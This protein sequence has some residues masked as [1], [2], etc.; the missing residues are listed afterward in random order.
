MRLLLAFA[1]L[2]AASILPA[3]AQSFEEPAALIEYAYQQY[4]PGGSGSFE[5][6]E[7]ASADLQALY[8]A[9]DAQTLDGEV[10]AL[11]FDPIINGQ[12]YE[13]SDVSMSEIARDD[14]NAIVEVSF[15]NFEQ[16][17]S[18]RYALVL[19]EDGWKIDEI[20][21]VQPGFEWQLTDIL[22]SVQ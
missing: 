14:A 9:D 19:T 21:S 20:Q 22:A 3:S 5:V 13:I 6:R 16:V 17:Q 2:L 8:E 18:M 10:G 1:A 12:D 4:G 15:R 7:H 11:D